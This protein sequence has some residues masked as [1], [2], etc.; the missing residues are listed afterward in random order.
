RVDGLV[1]AFDRM[2]EF[3]RQRGDAAHERTGDAEDVDLQDGTSVETAQTLAERARFGTPPVRGR[4]SV[5]SAAPAGRCC[6]LRPSP[7]ACC[8][9]APTPAGGSRAR[10]RPPSPAHR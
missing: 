9:P 2:A 1:A 8:G 10:G 4:F 5:R 6:R 7:P 3:A